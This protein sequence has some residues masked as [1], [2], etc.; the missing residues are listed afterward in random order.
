MGFFKNLLNNIAK[1]A[2]PIY[3]FKDNTLTFKISSEESHSYALEDYDLKSRHDPYVSEAY[4]LYNKDIFLE[5]IRIANDTTWNGS[6]INFYENMFKDELKIKTLKILEDFEV[7]TY[8]FKIFEID[9]QFIVFFIY[10]YEVNKDVFIID[11]KGE[12]YNSL[13]SKKI[14]DYV[15][16]YQDS[17]KGDVNFNMSLV[18]QNSQHEYFT[19]ERD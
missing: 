14:H 15:G 18:K 6:A 10:I 19:Y 13:A 7:D 5:Y 17:L 1:A 12:L 11:T 2:R 8:V 4:T 16:K 9:E 3:T